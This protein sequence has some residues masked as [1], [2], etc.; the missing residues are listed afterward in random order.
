MGYSASD[1]SR[2]ARKGPSAV[3]IQGRGDVGLPKIGLELDSWGGGYVALRQALAVLGERRAIPYRIVNADADD[4]ETGGR[5]PAAPSTYAP[6]GS[7]RTPCNS[8]ARITAPPRWPETF[9][10]A[11]LEHQSTLGGRWARLVSTLNRRLHKRRK[12]R[13]LTC[14]P[15]MRS[16][17]VYG[18]GTRR[19]SRPAAIL[20]QRHWRR[21]R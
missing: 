8:I 3:H 6:S 10:T 15:G 20:E 19:R 9:S 14:P 12:S 21:A 16:R 2:H 1:L 11:L 13:L 18:Q 17:R 4:G 7:S 5:I